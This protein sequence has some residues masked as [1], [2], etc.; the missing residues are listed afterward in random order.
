MIKTTTDVT[1]LFLKIGFADDKLML[2][3]DNK[4][5]YLTDLL[6]Q[7]IDRDNRVTQ[8]RDFQKY[9]L[10]KKVDCMLSTSIDV[11]CVNM[12]VMFSEKIKSLVHLDK[13]AFY[14]PASS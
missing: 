5:H 11:S 9:S 10:S 6:L 3:S 14:Y 4:R 13:E 1:D 8:Y 2:F 12:D 7:N